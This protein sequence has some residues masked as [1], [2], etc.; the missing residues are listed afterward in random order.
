VT[1]PSKE[2]MFEA[3]R[4]VYDAFNR[5]DA[6]AFGEFFTHDVQIHDLAS[7]PEQEMFR[8]QEGVER[9]YAMQFGVWEAAWGD[10]ER[11][12][13]A[14]PDRVLALARHGAKARSGPEVTQHRGVLFAFSDAGKIKEV[15]FFAEPAEGLAAAGL[16][17][18]TAA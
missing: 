18:H 15:R 3:V 1:A 7:M 11:L 13:E 17:E 2:E 8:G 12:L 10:I 14:G 5:R 6:D 16:D 4:R 9:F